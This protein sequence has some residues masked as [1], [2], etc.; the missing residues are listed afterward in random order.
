MATAALPARAGIGLKLAQARA[1]LAERP[2]LGFLE[3]HAENLMGAGG[4]PHAWTTALRARYPLSLHG[5]AL[6]LGADA[7]LDTEHLER[8][9]ELCRRYEPATFSEHVAWSTHDPF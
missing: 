4:P 6:S 5:V 9:A 2:D 8:L 7:P 1:L 3:V